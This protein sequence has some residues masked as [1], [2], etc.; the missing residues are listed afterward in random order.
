MHI[1]EITVHVIER[2]PFSFYYSISEIFSVP[3]AIFCLC[4]IILCGFQ[5]VQ[6]LLDAGAKINIKD[7]EEKIPIHMATE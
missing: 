1:R 5:I 3:P 2:S 4:L 7:K 6:T